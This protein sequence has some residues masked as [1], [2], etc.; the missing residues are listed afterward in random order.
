MLDT[1]ALHVDAP[2]QSALD[3]RLLNDFQ[4]GFPFVARPYAVLAE[5]LGCS[6]AEVMARLASLRA[7]GSVSRIGAVFAPGRV[8]VSTL[9][10][11]AV[12]PERL[13][14]VAALVSAHPEV[15]HNY[16]REHRFNL[17]YV[18]TAPHAQAL[19]AVLANIRVETGCPAVVAPLL[20][21]YHIDLGFDM[22]GREAKYRHDCL[23]RKQPARMLAAAER[24]IVQALAE[25]LLCVERP[26][27]ALAEAAAVN[28]AAVLDYLAAWLAEGLVKRFGVIVR[29][30][31]L[32]YRANAMC[33]WDVPDEEVDALGAR[34]AAIP[35]VNLCYRRLRDGA[36][37]PYNLY[38]MIHGRDRDAVEA[39]IFG[40]RAACGLGE[41][42]GAVLFSRRRFKQCGARYAA[43]AERALA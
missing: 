41:Y 2:D 38:C 1:S 26:Y 13:E 4:R 31:E 34:L 25:G 9:A 19:A 43:A 18:A 21:E 6:Q 27:L 3:F 22:H 10:A 23:A 42:R 24:R 20:R 40:L 16:E 29:H 35:G 14:A 7:Q 12:P 5:R 11:L 32:G 8:G 33:V 15:N 36:A 39:Q 30:H 37:W 28:E 17:W